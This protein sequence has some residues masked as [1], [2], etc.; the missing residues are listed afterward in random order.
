MQKREAAARELQIRRTNRE[1]SEMNKRKIAENIANDPGRLVDHN[2]ASDIHEVFDEMRRQMRRVATANN[3]PNNSLMLFVDVME[4]VVIGDQH[5]ALMAALFNSGALRGFTFLD[6]RTHT[7]QRSIEDVIPHGWLQ[8]GAPL[9]QSMHGRRH[10]DQAPDQSGTS[11]A[12]RFNNFVR[13]FG[14]A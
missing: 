13:R 3:S 7:Q 14:G 9:D 1:I 12:D 11:F 2:D 8:G 4:S 6:A 10:G 5:R